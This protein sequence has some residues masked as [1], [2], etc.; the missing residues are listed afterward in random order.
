M[1]W[2]S[3]PNFEAE[4]ERESS[5]EHGLLA[6]AEEVKAIAERIA[7]RGQTGFYHESIRV[8]RQGDRIFV[9]TIDWAGHIVEWGSVNSP[10]YGVLRRACQEAG[11]ELHE[12]PRR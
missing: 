2:R 8:F 3:N 5:V 9:G 6:F 1:R 11:L 12:L 7:P 10:P 4:L